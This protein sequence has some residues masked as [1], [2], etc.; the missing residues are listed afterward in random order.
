MDQ[1]KQAAIAS[2]IK[3]FCTEGARLVAVY[4]GWSAD[5]GGS[6]W[7]MEAI[8]EVPLSATANVLQWPNFAWDFEKAKFSSV[9]FVLDLNG[10]EDSRPAADRMGLA[11]AQDLSVPF[12]AQP[13]GDF[14]TEWWKLPAGQEIINNRLFEIDHRLTPSRG[15]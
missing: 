6:W 5:D 12:I 2:K 13:V 1:V 4:I 3:S 15:K 9:P 10:N 14:L 7:Q 11:I 8:Y